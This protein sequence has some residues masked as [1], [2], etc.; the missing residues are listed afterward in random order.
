VEEVDILLV[1]GMV[2]VVPMEVPEDHHPMVGAVQWVPCEE[3][4]RV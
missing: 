2:G 1:E 3:P 4:L